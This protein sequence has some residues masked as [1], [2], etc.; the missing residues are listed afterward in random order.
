MHKNPLFCVKI[1]G[2]SL[3]IVVLLEKIPKNFIK[4]KKIDVFFKKIRF[5]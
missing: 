3:Q 5:L 2:F 4:I 1:G